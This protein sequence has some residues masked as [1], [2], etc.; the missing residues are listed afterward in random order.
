MKQD[1]RFAL[2]ELGLARLR[3]SL[4]LESIDIV[5]VGEDELVLTGDERGVRWVGFALQTAA[6]RQK[7]KE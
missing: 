6:T 7:R 1:V 5:A 4:D 2:D 3:D